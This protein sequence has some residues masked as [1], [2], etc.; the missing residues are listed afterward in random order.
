MVVTDGS[1]ETG[2]KQIESHLL[3]VHFV[4]IDREILQFNSIFELIERSS[5][6]RN[7]KGADN[8]DVVGINVT[9]GKEHSKTKNSS[10]LF[11]S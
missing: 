10:Q 6:R 7:C 9:F 2:V 3:I 4:M 5:F 1:N 11:S 8:V